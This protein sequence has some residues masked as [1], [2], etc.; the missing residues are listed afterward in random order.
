M[1]PGITQRTILVGLDVYHKTMVGRRSIAGFVA[2]MDPTFTQYWSASIIL[3]KG[4]ELTHNISGYMR[5][6]LLLYRTRN[7][8]LPDT[9]IFY[10][11]GVGESQIDAVIE[12][13]TKQIVNIF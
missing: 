11:D 3:G 10:R 4:Q 6:A 12:I 7:G 13:E 1:P 2:S 5:E 9:I 8:F